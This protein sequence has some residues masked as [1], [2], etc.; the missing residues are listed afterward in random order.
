MADRSGYIGRAPGDSAVII[1]KQTFEPSGIQTNFTFS[2]GYTV[3][4][5]DAY[6]NGV[7]LIYA[8]DYTATDGSVVGL[9]SF[10]Q[11]G[12]VVELVAYK[13]FN[14]SNPLSNTAGGSLEVGTTLD[15]GTDLTVTGQTTLSGDLIV[16]GVTTLA[17]GSSVSLATTAYNLESGIWTNTDTTESTATNDG[18]LVISGGV[19]IAKSLNVGGNVTVGGTLTYEDVTNLDVLGIATYRD[20]LEVG[21]TQGSGT[22]AGVT[23]TTAGNAIFGKTGVV[24][25]TTFVGN[26]TGDPTGT[27]QTAAQPNITSLGTIQNLVATASSVTGIS[28]VGLAI[29]MYGSAGIVSATAFYGDGS[30]LEGVAASGGGDIDITSCLFI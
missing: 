28:S 16:A 27:V 6:L 13:A 19:G 9:T 14:I 25:A 15:V 26:L 24:T 4:Y 7:R 3:G 30:N 8:T 22:G 23:I 20:R 17:V 5:M 2:S 11:D 21:S 12:D 1:A 10:A 18:A 29:T